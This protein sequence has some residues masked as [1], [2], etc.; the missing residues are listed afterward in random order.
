M[1]A[2]ARSQDAIPI[3]QFWLGV[4]VLFASGAVTVGSLLQRLDHVETKA[5]KAEAENEKL[6]ELMYEIRERTVRI[7]TKLENGGSNR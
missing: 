1:G 5:V 3:W 2:M 4:A 7:E 6:Y